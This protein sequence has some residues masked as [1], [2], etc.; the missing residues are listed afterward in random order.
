MDLLTKEELKKGRGFFKTDYNFEKLKKLFNKERNDGL[1]IACEQGHD[2]VVEI[3]MKND[4]DVFGT[5]GLM[6]VRLTSAS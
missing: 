4:H 3:L 2:S 6:F 5:H 1:H